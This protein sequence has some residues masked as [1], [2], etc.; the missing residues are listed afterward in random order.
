MIKVFLFIEHS[1]CFTVYYWYIRIY[2]Q[3]FIDIYVYVYVTEI[4]LQTLQLHYITENTLQKL[5]MT[6]RKRKF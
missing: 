5:Q 1:N 3:Y 6:K 2:I 4:T